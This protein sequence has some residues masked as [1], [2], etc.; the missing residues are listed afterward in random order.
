MQRAADFTRLA[1]GIEGLGLGERVRIEGDDRVNGRA[2]L[3]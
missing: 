2:F 1:L 3:S